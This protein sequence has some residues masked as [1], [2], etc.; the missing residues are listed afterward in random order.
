MSEP[1]LLLLDEPSFALSPNYIDIAFE[2]I[3]EMNRNYRFV[4]QVGCPHGLKIS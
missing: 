2:K 3:N 4:N 1:K